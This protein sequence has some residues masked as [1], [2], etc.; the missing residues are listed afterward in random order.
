MQFS[1][2]A[3]TQAYTLCRQHSCSG[4]PQTA[5]NTA[6]SNTL[7]CALLLTQMQLSL[8]PPKCV[9]SSSKALP[10]ATY[11]KLSLL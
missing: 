5:A 3:E 8:L 9:H 2:P 6:P 11:D 4:Q 1:P 10:A 7:H